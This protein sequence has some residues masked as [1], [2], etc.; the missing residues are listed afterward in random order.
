MIA[1]VDGCKGGW[2]VVVAAPWPVRG[3]IR[4]MICRDFA[5]VLAVTTDC[6]RVLVDMP[7]GLPDGPETWPRRC[8][9]EGKRMLGSDRDKSIFF[10]PPRSVMTETEFR[11]FCDRQKDLVGKG[12]SQQA[13]A[14]VPKIR[15]I[16]CAMTPQHQDRVQEYHPELAWLRANGNALMDKKSTTNG[17]AQR[18][19]Y[20]RE[21]IPMLDDLETWRSKL[22]KAAALDDLFDALIGLKVAAEVEQNHCIP[23]T[24]PVD[25]KG[26]RMEIW[27]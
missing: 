8:D 12:C 18:R 2:L 11:G 23:A 24:P 5:T 26:L 4:A 6:T 14:I 25:G 13:F 17:K 3:D 1:G 20:L 27:Y 9:V 16:D 22:G 19:E 7:I 21:H 10:A 15:Q